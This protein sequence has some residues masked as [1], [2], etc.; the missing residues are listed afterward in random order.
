MIFKNKK[1][2]KDRV[3]KIKHERFPKTI[4]YFKVLEEINVL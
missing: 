2:A 1:I 3:A 4:G